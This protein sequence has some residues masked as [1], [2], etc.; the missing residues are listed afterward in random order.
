MEIYTREQAR[1]DP[2]KNVIMRTVGFE[3]NVEPDIYQYKYTKNDIFLFCSDGLYGKVS[4][5]DILFLINQEITDVTTATNN[6]LERI[7][8]RLIDLAN[9]NGGDDNISVIIVISR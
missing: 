2:H 8:E 6:D 9:K 1:L 7:V 3:Q 4:D 5:E